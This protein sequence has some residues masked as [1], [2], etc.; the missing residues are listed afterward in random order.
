MQLILTPN[1]DSKLAVVNKH[2][3][4]ILL[5]IDDRWKGIGQTSDKDLLGDGHRL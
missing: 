3:I 5:A 1:V 4:V 2:K